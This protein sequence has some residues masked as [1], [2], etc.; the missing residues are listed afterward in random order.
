MIEKLKTLG[1]YGLISLASLGFYP[2]LARAVDECQPPGPNQYLLLIISDTLERQQKVK[3]GLPSDINL[4]ICRY[5]NDTVTRIP[6]FK[7]AE[8]ANDWARYVQDI[9]G[10]PAYVVGGNSGM[11]PV[12]P[13]SIPTPLPSEPN[14]DQEAGYAVL[15]DYFNQPELVAKL[16]RELGRKVGLASYGQRLFLLVDSTKDQNAATVTLRNLSDRG[17]WTLVVDSRRIMVVSPKV[18]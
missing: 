17:F 8:V 3:Q 10:L 11:D 13:V 15:V 1:I 4:G 18:N 9:I 12:P 14:P 16:E 6:G 2:K 5:V 7:D